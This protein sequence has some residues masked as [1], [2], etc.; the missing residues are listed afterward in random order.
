MQPANETDLHIFTKRGVYRF[1]AKPRTFD[2][3]KSKTN[4]ATF[5]SFSI[6]SSRYIPEYVTEYSIDR[7]VQTFAYN[8]A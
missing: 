6:E 3:E 4:G 5:L 8:M 1:S 2:P 7:N